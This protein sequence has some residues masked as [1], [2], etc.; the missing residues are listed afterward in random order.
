M[1]TFLKIAWRNILRNIFRSA[2]TVSS[3]GIGFASL[4]FI[5]SF[6]DG[7]DYQMVENYTGLFSGHIQIHKK[8]FLENPG[9]QKSISSPEKI[10]SIL[11]N[12]DGIQAVSKRVKEYALVSS[13]ENSTGV[14]LMGV[15]P[16]GEKSVTELYK[17]VREGSFVSREDEIVI[18]KSLAKSLNVGL[19]DK[20]VIIAQAYD[21]SL[22]SAAYRVSGLIDTGAEELDKGLAIITLKA[23]QELFVLDDKIS[24]FAVRMG[25]HTAVDKTALTLKNSIDAEEYE[26]LTWKEISPALVQWIEFDLAFSN[27]LLLIVLAIVAAGILNTLLMGIL[28]RVREFGIMLALG[29]KRRQ[30]IQMIGLE[31]LILGFIGIGLGYLLGAGLAGYFSVHG[32]NLASFSTALNEYYTGS[33]VYTRISYDYPLFYG[34]VVLL[35]SLIVSIYPAWRAANLK[36]VDAIRHM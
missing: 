33:V 20:I 18:G 3:I 19:K 26:L 34:A 4:F 6:I 31:S 8:G 16:E 10:Y 2:I 13:A 17:R 24:E 12:T 28:E 27:F 32:I 35:T 15:D 5:R 14:L 22:A 30:I 21:G 25:S 29:T 1:T 23:A 7:A 36:P 11:K 9:L